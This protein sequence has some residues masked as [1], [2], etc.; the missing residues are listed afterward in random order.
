MIPVEKLQEIERRFLEIEEKLADPDIYSDY[1]NFKKLAKEKSDLEPIVTKFREYKEVLD[2]IAESKEII[3][4]EDDEELVELAKEELKELEEKQEQ[5]E[6]ELKVL[7]LPKDPN[8]EKN[9][10]LE[11]RAAA[12]G[13]ELRFLPLIF[14]GCTQGTLK[15]RAG[16]FKSL[17]PMSLAEVDSRRL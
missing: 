9:I 7:L 2:R 4:S 13:E 15:G 1:K 5:L 16:R 14:S 10:F 12:G 6:R 8:D 17:T 11:I 3:D